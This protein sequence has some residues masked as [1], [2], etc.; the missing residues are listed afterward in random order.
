[1]PALSTLSLTVLCGLL[2][3]AGLRRLRG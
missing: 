3:L 2:A 1:V